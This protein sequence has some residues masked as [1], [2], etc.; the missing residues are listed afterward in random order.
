VHGFGVNFHRKKR[1]SGTFKNE[2]EEIRGIG[3]NTANQ[4][5]KTFR[6]VTGVR[7]QSLEELSKVIGVS[8]AKIVKAYFEAEE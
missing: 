4:L 2:L 5:L 3:E 7:Q 1:S 8:K 6:S